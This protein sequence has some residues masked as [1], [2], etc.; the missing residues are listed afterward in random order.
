VRSIELTLDP[1]AEAS[2]RAD[3][4]ALVDAEL[5]SLALHDAESNRPHITLAAGPAL[6]PVILPDAPVPTR[7][8]LGALSLFRT[9]PPGLEAR[10]IL[11]R[12]VV[13]D[14]ELAAFHR[15]LHV[16][17]HDAVPTSLPGAWSPH[18]T[19][20][21]RLSSERVGLALDALAQR[22]QIDE[23]GIEGVRFWN[24]DTKQITPLT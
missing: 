20:A 16:A 21:R 18:V 17:L 10:W 9:M 6:A 24:G 19:L 3:W 22:P 4:Q 11:V 12:A 8:R 1:A 13:V 15:A 5:P 7:V 2:F 23:A 14:E